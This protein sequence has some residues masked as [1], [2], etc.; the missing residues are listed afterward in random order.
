MAIVKLIKGIDEL[1]GA[2][3]SVKEGQMNRR[4][5]IV[6]FVDYGAKWYDTDGR[7][8]HQAY[9]YTFPDEWPKGCLE[10]RQKIKIAQRMA[11]DIEADPEAREPWVARYAM[12]RAQ[13]EAGDKKYYG[14]YQYVYVEILHGIYAGEV[15]I[16][17]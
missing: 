3:D 13:C 9:Y 14:F 8:L 5:L 10:N 16:I 17:C 4:R 1:H 11:H 15:V 6:R 12:Y 2:V 7:K